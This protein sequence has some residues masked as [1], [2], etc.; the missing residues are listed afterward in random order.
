MKY[1]LIIEKN[2]EIYP[3]DNIEL[4]SDDDNF[5]EH[6]LSDLISLLH[7]YES[8]EDFITNLLY[9]SLIPRELIDGNIGIYKMGYK[10]KVL[11]YGV[12]YK[13]HRSLYDVAIIKNYFIN[14]LKYPHFLEEFCHDFYDKLKTVGVFSDDLSIIRNAY[15]DLENEIDVKSETRQAIEHFIDVYTTEKKNNKYVR[16]LSRVR[17]LAMFI[18]NY[19]R[20]Y[21][22]KEDYNKYKD[23][24]Y[25]KKLEQVIEHYKLYIKEDGISNLEID[26]YNKKLDDLYE[27]YYYITGKNLMMGDVVDEVTRY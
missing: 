16:K 22:N 24:F 11:S 25:V 12:S 17:N 2:G 20:K 19:E 27:E 4:L 7:N 10:N 21:L 8:E 18:V 9:Y 3:I 14:Y 26:A 13:K 15:I 5:N 23:P 6:N 1:S